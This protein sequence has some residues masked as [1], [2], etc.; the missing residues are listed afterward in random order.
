MGGYTMDYWIVKLDQSG[1][2]EW[3]NTIGGSGAD[4]LNTIQ[5]TSDG[6]YIVG[7][8]SSSGCHMI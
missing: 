4:Y 7:G 6:G 8:N 2:I 5:Q 3:Q 1:N